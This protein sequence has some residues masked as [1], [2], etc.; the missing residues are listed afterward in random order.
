[1]KKFTLICLFFS[2]F[3]NAKGQLPFD[4][5][6]GLNVAA[7]STSDFTQFDI[8]DWE[9]YGLKSVNPSS[10]EGR[11]RV[12]LASMKP[13]AMNIG[14]MVGGVR[15]ISDNLSGGIIK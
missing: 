7:T 1:M 14:I 3:L 2:I 8:S 11:V 4:V 12:D 6:G 13:S 5:Y 10:V 9:K 15:K